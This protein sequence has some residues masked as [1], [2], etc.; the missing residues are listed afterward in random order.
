MSTK[1]VFE[2]PLSVDLSVALAEIDIFCFQLD[3]YESGKWWDYERSR[4]KLT[5][6]AVTAWFARYGFTSFHDLPIGAVLAMR[7][8]LGRYLTAQEK[9]EAVASLPVAQEVD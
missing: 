1:E 2:L 3:F 4:R 9:G 7:D 5:H 8:S 6:P